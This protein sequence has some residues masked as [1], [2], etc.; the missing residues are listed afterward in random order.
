MSLIVEGK[1]DLIIAL[2]LIPKTVPCWTCGN[3][4]TVYRGYEFKQEK[5]K[6]FTLRYK[7]FCENCLKE[8]ARF[9]VD[10]SEDVVKTITMPA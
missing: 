7:G 4:N 2:L 3:D 10:V 9:I 5:E 1:L 6:V 8:T